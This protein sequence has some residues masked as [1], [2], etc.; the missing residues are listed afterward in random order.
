MARKGQ[1]LKDGGMWGDIGSFAGDVWDN[2]A[3]A[4]SVAWE[5]ITD[6]VGAVKTHIGRVG[7]GRGWRWCVL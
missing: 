1:A 5:F 7:L 3:G 4:A 6:P 2:I